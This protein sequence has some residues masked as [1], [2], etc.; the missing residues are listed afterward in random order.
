MD[1]IGA[2]RAGWPGALP[3]VAT[4]PL[5]PKGPEM[6]KNPRYGLLTLRLGDTDITRVGKSGRPARVYEGRPH[7][8]ICVSASPVPVSCSETDAHALAAPDYVRRLQEDLIALGFRYKTQTDGNFDLDTERALR[9]FQIYARMPYVAKEHLA[10]DRR[11]LYVDRLEQV[12]NTHAYGGKPTGVLDQETANLLAHWKAEAWRCP[13]VVVA[14]SRDKQKRLLSVTAENLWRFDS[15]TANRVAQP[16][17]KGK[18]CYVLDLSGYF[19]VST[20]RAA[21]EKPGNSSDLERLRVSGYYLL[22]TSQFPFD[23]G[24]L[25]PGNPGSGCSWPEAAITPESFMG[26][27]Y[28]ALSPA[29]RCTFRSVRALAE[30]ECGGRLDGI[31]AYDRTII[32]GGLC[33]WAL[34]LVKRKREKDPSTKKTVVKD[35]ITR[36]DPGELMGFLAEFA[37]TEPEEWERLF[38]V[39]GLHAPPAAKHW[40]ALDGTDGPVSFAPGTTELHA[41]YDRLAYLKSWHWAYRIQMAGRTSRKYHRANFLYFK[42]RYD[43]VLDKEWKGDAATWLGSGKKLRDVFS[44]EL[45]VTMLV[46]WHVF[47]PAEV[48]G[49]DVTQP[50]KKKGK[51]VEIK[52]KY[53]SLPK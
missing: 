20:A 21:N 4:N 41:A 5:P 28:A 3:A 40:C 39:F 43:E 38:G 31:N 14:V 35:V 34:C 18:V 32:S 47:L 27:P 23:G 26:K 11:P 9:E 37:R 42:R 52:T 44:A 46:R 10:T 24:P 13:V 12:P 1:A 19:Q 53:R 22:D 33:H 29:E 45:L 25:A 8:K 48:G 50:M 16:T 49:D 36:I 15:L 51:D 7:D 6:P 17:L 30:R 2:G